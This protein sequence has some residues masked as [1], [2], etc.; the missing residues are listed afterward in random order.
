LFPFILQQRSLTVS[1]HHSQ[2]S[3]TKYDIIR[4]SSGVV[5]SLL[6]VVHTMGK[7]E[8]VT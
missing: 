3:T 7:T 6:L 1:L 8:D 2:I 4:I 5:I